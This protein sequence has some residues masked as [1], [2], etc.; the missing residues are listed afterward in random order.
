MLLA[1]C[2]VPLQ[3]GLHINEHSA[4][5]PQLRQNAELWNQQSTYGTINTPPAASYIEVS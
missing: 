5:K 2:L 4:P 1:N 3:L